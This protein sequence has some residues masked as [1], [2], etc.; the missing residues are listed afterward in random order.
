[1]HARLGA[2]CSQGLQWTP[3]SACRRLSKAVTRPRKRQYSAASSVAATVSP[4][5]ASPPV[6]S[7]SPGPVEAPSETTSSTV[8]GPTVR[9]ST[10]WKLPGRRA[11]VGGEPETTDNFFP[12]VDLHAVTA[13]KSPQLARSTLS[14]AAMYLACGIDPARSAVFVQNHVTAHAELCWLLG[15][16]TPHG[17]LNRMIQFKEKSR[18]HGES[19]SMGLFSYPLLQA[20]DVLLYNPDYVPVGEDQRQHIE[21]ARD[22]AKRYNDIYCANRERKTFN[23]PELR[24]PEG[25][26]RIMALDDASAKMSKSAE[27][28]GSRINMTDAPEVILRKVKRCKTDSVIGLEFDNPD[29]PECNNLLTIYQAITGKTKDEVLAECSHM[30]WG[31]FKPLLGDALVDHVSPIR[32]RYEE[33]VKDKAYLA[34]VLLEGYEKAN[35]QATRTLDRV[36]KDMGFLK[37]SDLKK[38]QK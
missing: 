15:C 38:M 34:D 1:M 25:V 6:T 23:V 16:V 3:N 22:I 7:E 13:G 32:T 17:W 35:K 8:R 37:L 18:R 31:Q 26:A 4:Q 9:Q 2:F 28:E 21:L 20:A 5:S 14:A 19:A 29:R 30:K 24:M 36:K 10:P 12:V 33:L 27:N 11:R